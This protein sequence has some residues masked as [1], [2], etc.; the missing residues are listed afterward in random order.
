MNDYERM[1]QE[2]WN[3]LYNDKLR[4]ET[5]I[6]QVSRKEVFD[7][8]FDRAFQLG[9]THAA[10]ESYE[11]IKMPIVQLPEPQFIPSVRLQ[12]AAMAMQGL[13]ANGK[14]CSEEHIAKKAVA[15]ADALL[16]ELNKENND[17]NSN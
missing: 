5:Q 4:Y 17:T 14:L 2:C 13:V 10:K 6:E 15:I 16:N 9:K 3:A 11:P 8:V 7:Y 12:V 1:K